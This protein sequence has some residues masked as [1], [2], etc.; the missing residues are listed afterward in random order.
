MKGF[1]GNVVG[2]WLLVAIGRW[3]LI[4]NQVLKAKS[5]S[6]KFLHEP[7]YLD[8]IYENVCINHTFH[9]EYSLKSSRGASKSSLIMIS[10]L[11]LPKFDFFL[12]EVSL[13]DFF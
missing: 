4:K 13:E 8:Y 12:P 10:P 3:L 2:L 9:Y 11:A 6:T 7:F 5:F 1:S